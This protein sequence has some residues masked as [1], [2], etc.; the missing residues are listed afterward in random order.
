MGRR[1]LALA[2]AVAIVPGAAAG[3]PV[4]DAARRALNL[5]PGD[6]LRLSA[7]LGAVPEFRAIPGSTRFSGQLIVRR[8]TQQHGFALCRVGSIVF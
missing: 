3:P 8:L 6:E 2:A 7:G 4:D 1:A 5:T